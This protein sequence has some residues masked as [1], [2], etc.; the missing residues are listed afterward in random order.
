[1]LNFRLWPL[2][3]GLRPVDFRRWTLDSAPRTL[4]FRLWTL[5]FAFISP[6]IGPQNASLR[7]LAMSPDPNH[8]GRRLV[9]EAAGS[10]RGGLRPGITTAPARGNQQVLM[11]MQGKAPQRRVRQ[12][13]GVHR[14]GEPDVQS[15]DGP[16]HGPDAPLRAAPAAPQAFAQELGD[17]LQFVQRLGLHRLDFP[18]VLEHPLQRPLPAPQGPDRRRV[19]QSQA[20]LLDDLCRPRRLDRKSTRL[21]SS[22]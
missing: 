12:A 7:S 17:L 16:G 5:D 13:L 8:A 1:M 22:H 9:G 14:S 11:E 6:C 2:A 19:L 10:P 20:P 15:L 18:V 21:N 3:S 4:A